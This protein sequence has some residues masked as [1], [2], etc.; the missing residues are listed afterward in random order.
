MLMVKFEPKLSRKEYLQYFVLC[1]TVACKDSFGK[2]FFLWKI[3]Q[4]IKM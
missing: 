1:A 2:Y 3:Y 4:M